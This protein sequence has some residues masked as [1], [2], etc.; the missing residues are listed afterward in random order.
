M[1]PTITIDGGNIT[2]I[3]L[4]GSWTRRLNRPAQAQ[5][6]VPTDEIL[7]LPGGVGSRLKIVN[8]GNTV[9]HGMIQQVEYEGGEDVGY[10]TINATDP[11]EL[12]Q[13]RPV[14]DAD[15]DMSQPTIISDFI[16]GP[17]ILEEMLTN[18]DNGALIPS[19]SE[20]ELFLDLGTFETGGCDLSGAPTDWPMTIAQLFSLL[21]S[22]GCL[23]AVITPTDP[24][25]GVMGT[26]NAYNGDFGT[27]LSGSV[28]FQYGTGAFDI[29]SY[30]YNSDMTNVCNK[31]WYFMGPRISTPA[32]PQ[33]DQH[34]CYNV[35]GD[36]PG[37][38]DPIPNGQ[39]L[40]TLLGNR[41]SSRGTYGVRMEVQIFDAG[42]C[43]PD[44]PLSC[45][46]PTGDPLTALYREL[47]RN[48]WETESYIRCFPRDLVHITPTRDAEIGTFDIGDLVGVIIPQLGVN[49]AQRVYTYTTS[50]DE[51]GVLALSELQT[52]A[53]AD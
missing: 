13:W 38:P 7:T 1:A 53:S 36:D 35:Q 15:G 28:T 20:G 18:S 4:R 19:L 43:T 25:G 48:R 8:G 17:Q 52:S 10:T 34:W 12:W 42:Q 41:A 14:R 30:R 39:S 31:L 49:A 26:V 45:C 16:T 9:F 21:V 37:L 2:N 22:T 6:V 33:G 44:D 27:D 5:V 29:R 47:Y 23:D 40:A 3:C 50:W 24:G 46:D 51:D 11:M 32:D